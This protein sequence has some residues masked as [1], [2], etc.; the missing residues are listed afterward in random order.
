MG[1]LKGPDRYIALAFFSLGCRASRAV[2]G[3]KSGPEPDTQSAC[4]K[5][6]Q[7]RAEHP[8]LGSPEMKAQWDALQHKLCHDRLA[9]VVPS[10]D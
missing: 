8:T 6:V 7:T 10:P 1:R 2:P 9:V 3:P 4:S 5:L